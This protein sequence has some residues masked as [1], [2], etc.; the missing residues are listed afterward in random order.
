MAE[1]IRSV[2]RTTMLA[3][4]GGWTA[5]PGPLYVRLAAAMA[6][7]IER[8]DISPGSRLPAE[9]PLAKSLAVSRGTVMAAYERLRELGWADSRQGS[10]T[11]IRLDVAR[12]ID[13]LNDAGTDIRFRA[14]SARLLEDKQGVIDLTIGA[15][16]AMDDL[17]E[18]VFV[19]P[20]R[21]ALERLGSGHGY[22]P[23]GLPALRHR[24]TTYY[25]ERETDT[26]AGQIAVT[27][28]AQQ[29]ISLIAQLVLKPGDAVIVESPTYPGA[30]DAFSRAGARLVTVPPATD[31]PNVSRL[32]AA[33][34][35]N[36]ARLVYL[37]PACH[38]PL[39]TVMTERRRREIADVVDRHEVYLVED[40]MLAETVF[41]GRLAAPIAAFSRSGRVVTLGSL[42]KVGWGGLRTGWMRGSA[43]VIDRV[44]RLKA[45]T[46]FGTAVQPQVTAC[47]VLDRLEEISAARRATLRV[48]ADALQ[49]ELARR[50]PAWTWRAP[51]GGLALWVR[52]PA[53]DADTFNQHAVRHGVDVL[54]GSVLCADGQDLD[55]VRI[56][57]GKSVEV[58]REGAMRLAR[59]WRTYDA[60]AAPVAAPAD[61]LRRFPAV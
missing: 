23:L 57:F 17:P 42:S 27:S 8:G 4:L 60:S 45:A 34:G 32:R 10:G 44:A 51:E 26:T 50:L 38:N 25:T 61:R 20:T 1:P 41:D 9:R 5:G 37:M 33:I 48:Q 49:E 35:A 21:D 56:A 18:D 36:A 31:W 29:A 16:S 47:T 39:G 2:D 55:C 11:W 22:L 30:I 28:G 7:A 19:P 43:D 54:P 14:L 52:L 46:D 13:R 59:A 12:P 40:N 3:H 58:L 6:A 24:I 15:S 53:G